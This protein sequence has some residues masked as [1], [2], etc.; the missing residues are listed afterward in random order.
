MLKPKYSKYT[1][2]SYNKAHS[3][4]KTLQMDIIGVL[5]ESLIRET[6]CITVLTVMLEQ[7]LKR[8]SESIQMKFTW[9]LKY[10]G[11][12]PLQLFN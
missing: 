8:A 6:S 2:I 1:L 5:L 7:N 11:K 12:T 3:V 4:S 10:K 9:L